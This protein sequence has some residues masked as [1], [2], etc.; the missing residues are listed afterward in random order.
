M[1]GLATSGAIVGAEIKSRFR[2][3]A[4]LLAL[5]LAALD[6]YLVARFP[7][8]IPNQHSL[9][10]PRGLYWTLLTLRPLS[11]CLFDIMLA[12]IIYLASTNRLP[13]FF[14]SSPKLS[15][16]D[17]AERQ[18][19][20]LHKLVSTSVA[21][22]TALTKLRAC[23]MAKNV[24]VKDVRGLKNCEDAYWRA[25]AD[26]ATNVAEKTERNHRRMSDSIWQD[27]PV[28]E[29]M[30]S[31]TSSKGTE[32]GSTKAQPDLAQ[33]RKEARIW[34]DAITAGLELEEQEKG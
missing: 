8:P 1:L 20:Q 9:F 10:P 11:V 6:V 21:L 28:I 26:V 31:A 16:S 15:A 12:S 14:D 5:G 34:V 7:I 22:Q 17:E 2:N 18:K 3:K 32:N 29:A 13:F 19:Q 25:A 4:A 33:M 23:N 30:V 24:V 27:K